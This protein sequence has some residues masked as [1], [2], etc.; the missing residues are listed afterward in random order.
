MNSLQNPGVLYEQAFVAICG[1]GYALRGES[2]FSATEIV[3]VTE[4]AR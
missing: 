1:P 4:P 2:E 3:V